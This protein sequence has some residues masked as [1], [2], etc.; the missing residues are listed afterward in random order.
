MRGVLRDFGYELD[1]AGECIKPRYWL[2][3]DEQRVWLDRHDGS[4]GFTFTSLGVSRCRHCDE[5][6]A[7]VYGGG[8][9]YDCFRYLA[10]CD[11]CVLSPDRCHWH[12][13]T[14]R[15]AD[16]GREFCMQPHVMYLANSSGPKVGLTRR[17]RC[18]ARWVDQGAR[19]AMIIA[20]FASRRTAGYAEA[21]LK[22]WVA[23]TTD[24]RRLVSGNT[25]LVDL[26]SLFAQLRPKCGDLA[27]LAP[28][29]VDDEERS[30][31]RWL[32]SQDIAQVSIEYPYSSFAP[33][34]I[35]FRSGTVAG[36]QF[37][38]NFNG[39]IGGYF[40]FDAGAV[41]VGDLL[42]RQVELEIGDAHSAE[43]L[44][45]QQDQLSLF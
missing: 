8:Y 34:R 41:N 33:A 36:T 25:R 30:A 24:W 42:T 6:I 38:A 19:S 10:R 32:G 39:I 31:M 26:W 17:N 18:P 4:L 12:L 2:R 20:E 40:L 29:F 13:G 21:H 37:R 35:A 15:E 23:D 43:Q 9:C 3:L 14:C 27:A 1:D 16:W 45:D 22:Q 44:T 7:K 5:E 28:D 11:L